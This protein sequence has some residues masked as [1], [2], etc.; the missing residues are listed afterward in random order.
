MQDRLLECR[1]KR[2]KFI[3]HGLRATSGAVIMNNVADVWPSG[4]C[5]RRYICQTAGL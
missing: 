4:F 5:V 1:G 3:Y 2:L